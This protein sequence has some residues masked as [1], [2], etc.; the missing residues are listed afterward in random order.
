LIF[1]NILIPLDLIGHIVLVLIVN[2]NFKLWMLVDC[3]I[4]QYQVVCIWTQKLQISCV[5]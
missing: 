2:L 1:K 3:F 5:F 4:F